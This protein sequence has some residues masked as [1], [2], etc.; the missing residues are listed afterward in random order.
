MQIV[1]NLT[2]DNSSCDKSDEDDR[3]KMQ[4][5][6]S[7]FAGMNSFW[8]EKQKHFSFTFIV[9]I[10]LSIY[11]FTISNFGT[12]SLVLLFIK[13]RGVIELNLLHQV[14]VEWNCSFKDG[15]KREKTW[16]KQLSQN[17]QTFAFFWS[18][19]SRVFVKEK[20]HK[21]G[22]KIVHHLSLPQLQGA[23]HSHIVLGSKNTETA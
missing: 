18:H 7:L 8:Q 13:N 4:E 3:R 15:E 17:K 22:Y 23:S 19:Q 20:I 12:F 10:R 11:L 14:R 21:I 16:E 5:H 6:L 2:H 9:T 1:L